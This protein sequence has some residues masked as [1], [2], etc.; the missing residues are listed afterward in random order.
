M[1]R[2]WRKTWE[3]EDLDFEQEEFIKKRRERR[4]RKSL[5]DWEE[6]Y[7]ESYVDRYFN[8]GYSKTSRESQSKEIYSALKLARLMADITCPS[9][10]LNF[11]IHPTGFDRDAAGFSDLKKKQIF[12]DCSMFE[13][14]SCNKMSIGEKTDIVIGITLHE[15]LHLIETPV[16][17]IKEVFDYAKSEGID[18]SD[19]DICNRLKFI[20][21]ILEDERIEA[22]LKNYA[23]G[24]IGYIEKVAEYMMSER[25]EE[26]IKEYC[27]EFK[28]FLK[29]KRLS[30]EDIIKSS[31]ISTWAKLVRYPHL[32]D[33]E[34]MKKWNEEIKKAIELITP[35][36]TESE[37]VKSLTVK[38]YKEFE[39]CWD[40][41]KINPKTVEIKG[42]GKGKGKLGLKVEKKLEEHSSIDDKN[43]KGRIRI[44]KNNKG[45]SDS[46]NISDS[47][48]GNKDKVDD[49]D[50]DLQ[51]EKSI[52]I[53]IGIITEKANTYKELKT[54]TVR[55]IKRLEERSFE[56]IEGK[57]GKEEFEVESNVSLDSYSESLR[58]I[59]PNISKMV[60][61]FNFTRKKKGRTVAGLKNGKLDRRKL[62][63]VR[64]DNDNLYYRK[65]EGKILTPAIAIL[66]DMSGSMFGLKAT[67]AKHTAI[68]LT[69][70]FLR[71]GIEF[72]VYGHKADLG[73]DG[74]FSPLATS[75]NVIRFYS[76]KAKKESLGFLADV[77]GNN[78]DGVAIE[79]VVKDFKKNCKNPNKWL[80]VIS[81]GEPLARNYS[82]RSAIT[83]TANVIKKVEK[84]IPVFGI[85]IRDSSGYYKRRNNRSNLYSKNLWIENVSELPSKLANLIRKVMK[86]KIKEI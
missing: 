78:R 51:L 2:W 42:R 17:I 66:V 40:K 74:R 73:D 15:L 32:I 86:E 14:K 43:K 38:I 69:E 68:L 67:M 52:E 35:F 1:K 26:I 84:E 10:E 48:E 54:E 63:L 77:A 56:R 50:K 71:L 36:P 6:T 27:K 82:F 72:F 46:K 11:S 16:E 81:D 85:R 39:K 24:Y 76:P 62:Y 80:F 8:W 41:S 65:V 5:Y 57:F 61:I 45:E 7:D 59:G 55:E 9:S 70:V 28:T 83:H 3:D 4:I 13:S 34:V 20:W 44:R 23:P 53:I 29:K 31:W 64:S 30:V 60:K 19:S 33:K 47:K 18:I 12:V 22:K 21:N 49:E 25:M 75:T 79:M 58:E 37:E